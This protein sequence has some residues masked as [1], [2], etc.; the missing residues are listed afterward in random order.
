MKKIDQ[1]MK[2]TQS[3]NPSPVN[4]GAAHAY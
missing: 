4:L 3:K 1:I 2:L